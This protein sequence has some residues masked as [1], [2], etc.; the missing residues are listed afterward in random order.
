[1]QD[2]KRTQKALAT[3]P[4][5]YGEDDSLPKAGIIAM[6]TRCYL[7]VTTNEELL[8]GH[9]CIVPIQHHLTSLEGDD[10]LWEEIK[11]SNDLQNLNAR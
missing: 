6:G 11:V 8:D 5:C 10:D 1:V 3:C 7:A 4:Y 2:Y 9:V